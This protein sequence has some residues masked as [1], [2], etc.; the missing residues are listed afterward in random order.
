[1]EGARHQF[2]A[3]AG[4]PGDQHGRITGRDQLHLAVNGLHRARAPD[5]ARQR[6]L[7]AV[8]VGIVFIA[9]SAIIVV[10]ILL[11]TGADVS[12][13]I[14]VNVETGKSPLFFVKKSVITIV[15]RVSPRVF[16]FV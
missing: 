2:L 4:R 16:G 12:S 13:R 5:H 1:M 8:D 3:A 6:G 7:A 10:V 11:S 15:L 14:S 9:G